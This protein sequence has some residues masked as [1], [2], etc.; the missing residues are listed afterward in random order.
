M[1]D[2]DLIPTGGGDLAPLSPSAPLA[3]QPDAGWMVPTPDFLSE[4]QGY[5][6]TEPAIFGTPMSGATFQQAEQAIGQLADAFTRDMA[7]WKFDSHLVDAAARWFKSNA[8]L[9]LGYV[10]PTHNY[11]LQGYRIPDADRDAVTSFLNAM[12]EV[13][14][15]QRFV[16]AAL[17]WVYQLGKQGQSQQTK[18][19]SQDITDAEWAI[20][21]KRCE[22]DKAACDAALRNY[23]GSQYKL[24]LRIV[25]DYLDTLPV[26]DSEALELTVCKGGLLSGTI[27]K[28]GPA[29]AAEIASIEKVMKENR[30]AYLASESM[31][32]RLR[33]L[34]TLRGY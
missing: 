28:S 22:A 16:Q 30:K 23:W 31:Q 5:S 2:Y 8:L 15:P 29:I 21:E 12:A 1:S 26:Q 33:E 10:S 11:N 20:I 24:N 4:R 9:P 13:N 27:P 19:R 17:Y 18:S 14:A 32:A 7:G 34:Y 6:A 3:P 25:K